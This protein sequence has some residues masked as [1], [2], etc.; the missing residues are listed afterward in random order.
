MESI[1]LVSNCHHSGRNLSKYDIQCKLFLPTTLAI[2]TENFW[3]NLRNKQERWG[4]GT[5]ITI[6]VSSSVFQLLAM[7]GI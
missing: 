2:P 3:F 7:C 5:R 4:E 6:G 1:L